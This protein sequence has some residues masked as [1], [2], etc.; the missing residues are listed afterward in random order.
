M[1]K[2]IICGKSK[3]ESEFNIEHIIP[4]ALGNKSL[5]TNNVCE[6][7]N[8]KLGSKVDKYISTGF[9]M[10]MFRNKYK[11]TGKSNNIPFPFRGGV[12]K[13][14]N[15]INLDY[16]FKPTLLDYADKKNNKYIIKSSSKE[17]AKEMVKKIYKRKGLYTNK[18]DETINKI[19]N[20]KLK[21][22]HPTIFYKFQVNFNELELAILKIAYEYACLKLGDTYYNDK[23]GSKIRKIIQNAI[24]CDKIEKYNLIFNLPNDSELKKYINYLREEISKAHFLQMQTA[25]NN[26]FLIISLFCE[27]SLSYII[28]ISENADN[29]DITNFSDIIPLNKKLI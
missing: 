25:N 13:Y 22:I 2:C 14:G 11:V 27:I 20:I 26:I 4:E 19:E 23:Y 7:C 24:N 28:N 10:E 17:K 18:K 5:K 8:S 15:K 6:E 3:K 16:N 29:Y 21:S 9:L 12:D 1:K